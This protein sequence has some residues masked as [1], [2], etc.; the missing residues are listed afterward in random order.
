MG[1]KTLPLRKCVACN[2]MIS[3][4]DLFR[5]VSF[6]SSIEVDFKQTKPGR[7]AYVCKSKECL[8]LAVKKKSLNRSLKKAVPYEVI[9]LLYAELENGN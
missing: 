6:E 5:I 7:G 3:K 4:K 2:K 9:S 1:D 8:D